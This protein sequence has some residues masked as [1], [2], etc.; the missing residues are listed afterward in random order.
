MESKK[1][2]M[3]TLQKVADEPAMGQNE[4]ESLN[5]KVCF[6]RILNDNVNLLL[7]GNVC[8]DRSQLIKL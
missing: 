4:L 6:R 2:Y 1:Q 7:L 5:D 3:E 8:Y